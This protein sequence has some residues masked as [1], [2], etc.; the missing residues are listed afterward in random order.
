MRFLRLRN[1]VIALL[2]MVV[3]AS[4][5]VLMPVA[6]ARSS[7]SAAIL[8]SQSAVGRG[9]AV[10]LQISLDLGDSVAGSS[11]F[12]SVTLVMISPNE[13]GVL[14]TFTSVVLTPENASFTLVRKTKTMGTWCVTKKLSGLP[15][16]V[17]AEVIIKHHELGFEYLNVS[18]L[19]SD[20]KVVLSKEFITHG[21]SLGTNA[22]YELVPIL[23]SPNGAVSDEASLIVLPGNGKGGT[24]DWA[25]VKVTSGNGTV[26][27]SDKLSMSDSGEFEKLATV[28]YACTDGHTCLINVTARFDISE[29]VIKAI[30]DSNLGST[31]SYDAAT[32]LMK[33][34][35]LPYVAI[36]AIQRET[37]Y[38]KVITKAAPILKSQN[39]I[40]KG[41]I[42][43]R[44]YV[45]VQEEPGTLRAS[46]VDI[47]LVMVGENQ[48]YV[49]A[50]RVVLIPEYEAKIFSNISSKI[51]ELNS[52]LSSTAQELQDTIN[53]IKANVKSLSNDLGTLRSDVSGIKTK[54][55]NLASEVSNAKNS[56]AQLR[57]LLSN[58][59]DSLNKLGTRVST[60][61]SNVNNRVGSLS[62]E[63]GKLSQKLTNIENSINTIDNTLKQ[64][65][66]KVSS[67]SEELGNTEE[68]VTSNSAS[69]RTLNSDVH[70]L[71][72]VTY[73][74]LGLGVL[75]AILGIVGIAVARKGKS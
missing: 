19:D 7:G 8:V 51:S 9:E 10:T 48:A 38:V 46:Y 50:I 21:F 5:L 24:H 75:G 6:R 40:T 73:A 67:V 53:S 25:E 4:T 31:I 23:M 58:V 18:L 72:M 3:L 32:K 45:P 42:S 55:G 44:T 30:K 60:E 37:Y 61:I 56:I 41:S 57:N 35:K 71:V 65:E 13:S 28:A 17:L 74:A 43:F 63:L 39:V 64:L 22:I 59:N 34:G 70:N 52:K 68:N 27:Y 11:G 1:H 69:I 62:E 14:G 29:S 26:I 36:I 66:D 2:V 12:E 33:K 20:G 49:S 47:Y 15:A 54:V 16:G